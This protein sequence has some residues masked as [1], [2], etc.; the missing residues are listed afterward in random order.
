MCLR[1]PVVYFLNVFIFSRDSTKHCIGLI[2]VKQIMF[3]D[4]VYDFI[5]FFTKITTC[6]SRFPSYFLAVT[7]LM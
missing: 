3:K 4:V 2:E 5:I 7:P 1:I 6:M